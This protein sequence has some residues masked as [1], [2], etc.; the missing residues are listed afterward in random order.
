MVFFTFSCIKDDCCTEINTRIDIKYIDPEGNNLL[1]DGNG[2]IIPQLKTSHKI[3]G[4]WVTYYKPNLSHP[5]G[6]FISDDRG[7][8]H[9]NLFPSEELFD[10]NIS[11]T[12]IH[13]CAV[14]S[15][16]VKC[17]FEVSDNSFVCIKVWYN[18]ELV[19]E[20]DGNKERMIEVVKTKDQLPTPES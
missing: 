3:D 16:D 12:R 8:K 10:D 15:D 4:E 20:G 18:G 11:E 1:D 17:Q 5:K 19:W 6:F 7:E 14:H 2:I 9:L 13:Y